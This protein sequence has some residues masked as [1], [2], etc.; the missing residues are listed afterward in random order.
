LKKFIA[1]L[2]VAGI[3]GGVLLSLR[4][5]YRAFEGD[6]FLQIPKGS[7]TRAIARQLANDG[8]IQYAWQF[9]VARA[10]HPRTTLQAG[11]YRF[12]RAASVAEVFSRL[13]R[14]DVYYFNFTVPEG[15]NMFDIARLLESE[16]IMPAEDFLRAAQTLEGFLFPST[17]RLSHSTTPAAL[18]QM[19]TAQFQKEW[20]KL[21]PDP[22]ADVVKVVTLASLV[23]KET[24]VA[25]E[26]PIVAGVF[27]NRLRIGMALDCDPTVIYAALLQNRYRGAIHRSDL[28]SQHPYNTYQHTGLPPGP[29]ANPG[30]SSLAAALHP[31]ETAYLYFVAKP[32]GEGHVFSSN[33]AAHDKAV[34]NYRH[35]RKAR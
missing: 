9:W 17:Y 32:G 28:D 2:C 5:P 23:E 21:M 13:A 18:C 16:G 3:I 29:I 12:D 19:M 24:G 14:G 11:E 7:G 25:A 20:K 33:L 10:I 27:Q 8:I 15:S 30:T 31:A 22:A 34:G 35:A 26:R 1:L 6:L 4:S